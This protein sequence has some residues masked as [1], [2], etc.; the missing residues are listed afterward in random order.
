MPIFRIL[1]G[2]STGTI[3]NLLQRLGPRPCSSNRTE[4]FI[5]CLFAT[6][7]YCAKINGQEGKREASDRVED[8][9]TAV[10]VVG[11]NL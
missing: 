9:E 7:Q 2:Y 3:I 10:V 8:E 1:I 5:L 6:V 11:L 4:K